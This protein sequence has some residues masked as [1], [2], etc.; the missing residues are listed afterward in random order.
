MLIHICDTRRRR[1]NSLRPDEIWGHYWFWL[2]TSLEPRTSCCDE[3]RLDLLPV[4]RKAVTRPDA[5]FLLP[6]YTL[7][8][9]F[10]IWIKLQTSSLKNTFEMKISSMLSGLGVL[11]RCSFLP[12]SIQAHVEIALFIYTETTTH[13]NV[14]F[15]KGERGNYFRCCQRYQQTL[16]LCR[17]S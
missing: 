5:V 12:I 6:Q 16:F 3:D 15:P 4:R 11:K 9:K 8:D 17:Y 1:V 2:V 10:E 7:R 14:M 13:D